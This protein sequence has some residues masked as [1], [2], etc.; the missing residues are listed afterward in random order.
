MDIDGRCFST[1][2]CWNANTSNLE[3]SIPSTPR[4]VRQFAFRGTTSFLP[5]ISFFECSSVTNID[6]L[7]NGI[8]RIP[9]PASLTGK[10]FSAPLIILQGGNKEPLTSLPLPSFQ[11]LW[12][13]WLSDTQNLGFTAMLKPPMRSSGTPPML[14]LHYNP[15]GTVSARKVARKVEST[16]RTT[17][18]IDEEDDVEDM[19]DDNMEYDEEDEEDE[20]EEDDEEDEKEEGEEDEEDDEDEAEEEEDDVHIPGGG[21]D[22]LE[23]DVGPLPFVSTR[24]STR[25][26]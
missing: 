26:R 12:M 13:Q 9:L 3:V 19:D 21:D 14:R 5:E 22:E 4:E 15:T 25:S 18:S 2:V 7:R 20:E 10:L 6:G 24:G 1:A 11:Q 23:E 17:Q 8:L 16:K